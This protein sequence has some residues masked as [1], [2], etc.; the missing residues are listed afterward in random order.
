MVGY[1]AP[2]SVITS[3]VKR[4]RQNAPSVKFGWRTP[5]S[6]GR[7]SS[8]MVTAKE[9]ATPSAAPRK[10]KRRLSLKQEPHRSPPGPPHGSQKTELARPLEERQ[11]H[12]V[13]DDHCADQNG[14]DGAAVHGGL[15]IDQIS[16]RPSELGRRADGGE[17]RLGVVDMRRHLGDRDARR[18]FDEGQGD[19]ARDSVVALNGRE[20]E[21]APGVAEGIP[22]R[23]EADDGVPGAVGSEAVADVQSQVGRCSPSQHHL[24]RCG[25]ARRRDRRSP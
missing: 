14:E 23:V 22:R 3:A 16:V 11:E 1:R 5:L 8:T 13:A 10:A 6:A 21:H 9:R 2:I 18:H 4:A 19:N 7:F 24:V 12:G 15:K 17:F 20:R 25:R